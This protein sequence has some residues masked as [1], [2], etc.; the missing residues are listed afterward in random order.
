MTAPVSMNV[1]RAA[2]T[3]EQIPAYDAALDA[4]AEVYAAALDRR[5]ETYAMGGARAVA[6]AAYVPG[7]PSVEELA[8][9]YE[10]MAEQARQEKRQGRA[11]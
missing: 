11:A 1:I 8:A 7:G 9:R 6:E 4:A 3:P 10:A 5:D 2:L